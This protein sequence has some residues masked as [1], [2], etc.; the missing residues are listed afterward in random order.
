MRNDLVFKP[1]L[2]V[3]FLAMSFPLSDNMDG[4]EAGCRRER[5]AFHDDGACQLGQGLVA[6]LDDPE[7]HLGTE[8]TSLIFVLRRTVTIAIA[9][10]LLCALALLLVLRLLFTMIVAW[11]A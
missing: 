11:L 2:A 6:T 3:T 5:A 4:S 1:R 8:M 9:A 10:G 7:A